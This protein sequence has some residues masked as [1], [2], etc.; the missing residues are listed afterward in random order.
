MIFVPYLVIAYLSLLKV[1]DI[2]QAFQ[3]T[4]VFS[5]TFYF[6]Q[7]GIKYMNEIEHSGTN[8]I[9]RSFPKAILKIYRADG[10]IENEGIVWLF[11]SHRIY[12]KKV[13][14]SQ[15]RS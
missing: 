5:S 2:R 3:I 8:T 11:I 13:N 4:L 7:V 9:R 15:K 1:P 6:I 14:F 12:W 10:K